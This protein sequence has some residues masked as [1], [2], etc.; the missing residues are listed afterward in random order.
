MHVRGWLV[1]PLLVALLPCSSTLLSCSSAGASGGPPAPDAG[2]DDSSGGAES[3]A[4][5]QAVTEHGVVYSYGTLITSGNLVPVKG[6]TVTDGGQS[7]T[8]DAQGSWSLTLPL[9]STLAGMVSGTSEGDPFSTLA[10]VGATTT[11]PD[12]DHGNIII[13]DQSTFQLEQETL[14]ADASMALVHVL[15]VPTGA[16]TS[17]A[18]GTLAVTSPAGAQV[19]YF[20]TTGYPSASQTTFADL[21]DGRPV[22]DIYD[23]APGAP[24]TVQVT[25]P[26]CTMVPYPAAFGGGILTGQ[27][28]LQAAEPGDHN[29]ALI[30][31]LD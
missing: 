6:L 21:G 2:S 28:T 16:C 20:D 31:V 8:T 7:T 26:T 23:A 30:V 12:F 5:Q 14:T 10:L 15:V 13:P 9:G 29:A 17:A 18:G 4:A 22:A 27:V 25:H 3:G 11:G 1:T 24:L 19:M